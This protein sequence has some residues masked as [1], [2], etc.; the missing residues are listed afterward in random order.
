M[1]LLVLLLLVHEAKEV[2]VLV[3]DVGLLVRHLTLQQ[4]IS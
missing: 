1:F 2:G 3:I 4:Q